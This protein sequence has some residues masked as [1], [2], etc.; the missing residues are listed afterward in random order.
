MVLLRLPIEPFSKVNKADKLSSILW[1][2][3]MTLKTG[4]GESSFSLAFDI[5]TIFTPKIV[6]LTPQVKNFELENL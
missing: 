1:V 6:F 5:E 2:S 3:Q 4:F